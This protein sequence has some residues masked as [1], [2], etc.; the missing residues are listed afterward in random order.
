MSI[1]SYYFLYTGKTPDFQATRSTRILSSSV[2]FGFF[3]QTSM[4][5][6]ENLS[7]HVHSWMSVS[8]Y[9]VIFKCKLCPKRNL[10]LKR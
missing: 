2:T 4:I 10:D 7:A 9:I 6:G 1:Y 3:A 8:I 5:V